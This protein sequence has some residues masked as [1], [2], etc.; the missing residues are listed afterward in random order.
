MRKSGLTEDNLMSKEIRCTD[1]NK[2]L[3]IIKD[4]EIEL[5]CPRCK[6]INKEALEAQKQKVSRDEKI[7]IR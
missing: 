5:K 2:L 4:S 7:R 1:C 6:I 3:A